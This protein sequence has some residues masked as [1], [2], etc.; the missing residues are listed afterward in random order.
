LTDIGEWK[1]MNTPGIVALEFLGD[2]RQELEVDVV[3]EERRKGSQATT[4]GEQHLKQSVQSVQSVVKA[5]LALESLSVKSDVPVCC[6]INK[7]QKSRNNLKSSQHE[8]IE[9]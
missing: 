3:R 6:V 1:E 9:F 7:T 5:I 8:L 4:Q 2:V